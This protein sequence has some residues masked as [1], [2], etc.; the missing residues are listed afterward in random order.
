MLNQTFFKSLFQKNLFFLVDIE[1]NQENY[2]KKRIEKLCCYSIQK[3]QS[4]VYT[5]EKC[6]HY[7]EVYGRMLF[8][9][10]LQRA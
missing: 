6:S 8:K 1:I 3:F 10:C 7:Y 2:R 9:H 4:Y 5:L